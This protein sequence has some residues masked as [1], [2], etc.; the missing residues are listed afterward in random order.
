[1]AFGT[2]IAVY[3]WADSTNHNQA[4]ATLILEREAQGK[5]LSRSNRGGWHSTV[6]FFDWGGEAIAALRDQIQ[7][8]TR[9]MTEDIAVV[10][11]KPRQFDYSLSGWANINRRGC[12]NQVHYHPDSVWS[13]VYYVQ[14]GSKDPGWPDNGKLELLDPRNATCMVGIKDTVLDQLCYLDPAPGALV[15][16]PS[17]LKH[18]VHPFYGDGERI[19]IAFNVLV[20]ETT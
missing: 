19:S 8:I 6:D 13:G 17:W 3:A 5:N 15:V 20:Q 9:A 18:Q 11:D 2:P 12:Y 16:F 1:M 10:R 4:L 7:I 14:T